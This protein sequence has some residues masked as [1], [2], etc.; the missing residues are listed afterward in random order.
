MK[1]Q[2]LYLALVLIAFVAFGCTKTPTETTITPA[3]STAITDSTVQ[4]SVAGQASSN[5]STTMGEVSSMSTSLTSG[6]FTPKG[7]KSPPTNWT[8]GTDGWYMYTYGGYSEGDSFKLKFTPDIWASSP[9]Y[10]KPG[11]IEYKYFWN[12]DTSYTG[13]TLLSRLYYYGMGQYH[14]LDTTATIVEGTWLFDYTHHVTATGYDMDFSYNWTCNYDNVSIAP[15]N[16]QMHFTYTSHWPFYNEANPTAGIQFTDLTGEMSL[17]SSGY[18]NLGT[19]DYAGWTAT[20]GTVFV[21]YFIGS[22]G[23]Y[24]TLLGDGFVAH[25][26]W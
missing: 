26:T 14:L 16:D 20:N 15:G 9:P 22:G 17:N 6:S 10:H 24:Y 3:T 7:L 2:R 21:K 18:G 12:N 5:V 13:Y 11:K 23:R 25:H 19:G 1:Q 8:I 4:A